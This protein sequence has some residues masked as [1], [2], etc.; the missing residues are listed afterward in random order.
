MVEGFAEMTAYVEAIPAQVLTTAQRLSLL[1]K[2]KT[3]RKLQ[4]SISSG[5]SVQ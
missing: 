5:K 2:L 1:A 4:V 3:A